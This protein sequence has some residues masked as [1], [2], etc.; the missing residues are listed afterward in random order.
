MARNDETGQNT[1]GP[2]Q[3]NIPDVEALGFCPV[4]RTIKRGFGAE[5]WLNRG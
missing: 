2:D 1:Q 3:G 5:V 4:R